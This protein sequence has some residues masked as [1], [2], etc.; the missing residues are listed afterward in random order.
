MVGLGDGYEVKL[1]GSVNKNRIMLKIKRIRIFGVGGCYLVICISTNP[2]I[3][4]KAVSCHVGGREYA[5]PDADLMLQFEYCLGIRFDDLHV[6]TLVLR[7]AVPVL[8][9]LFLFLL[10]LPIL[11]MARRHQYLRELELSLLTNRLYVTL[12]IR[13][14]ASWVSAAE[15]GRSV[16][17]F[18][19]FRLWSDCAHCWP[20]D[21]ASSR[22]A[23]QIVCLLRAEI[24]ENDVLAQVES[25]GH[26][27]RYGPV[28]ILLWE[29]Y[30]R[31]VTALCALVFAHNVVD[32]FVRQHRLAALYRIERDFGER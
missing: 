10:L 28:A 1:L 17:H 25:F 16:P 3:I 13:A 19:A 18:H 24:G 7:L 6:D 20:G 22:A 26:G 11:A 2:A 32:S 30:Q 27:L 31:C 23:G 15:S 29:E 5:W 21:V 8:L 12:R 4:G 9:L 14:N